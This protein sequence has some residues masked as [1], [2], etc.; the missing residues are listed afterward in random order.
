ME[1]MEGQ[2]CLNRFPRKSGH[3]WSLATISWTWSVTAESWGNSEEAKFAILPLSFGKLNLILTFTKWTEKKKSTKKYSWKICWF[4]IINWRVQYDIFI[5]ML[6]FKLKQKINVRTCL[7]IRWLPYF[8]ANIW[9]F[10]QKAVWKPNR[11][12]LIF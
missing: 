1:K 6:V 12:L 2:T 7:Y 10:L 4:N 8:Y 9:I 11:D 5:H 3:M